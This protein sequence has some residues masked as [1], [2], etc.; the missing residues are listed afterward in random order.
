MYQLSA[1][2]RK[3][4]AIPHTSTTENLPVTLIEKRIGYSVV[5]KDPKIWMKLMRQLHEMYWDWINPRGIKFSYSKFGKLCSML[6]KRIHQIGIYVDYKT[7]YKKYKNFESKIPRSHAIIRNSYDLD[8]I[9]LVKHHGDDL[10]S[11]PG[12]KL[13]DGEGYGNALLRELYEEVNF[14]PNN[15]TLFVGNPKIIGSNACYEIWTLPR[16]KVR[17]NSPFEIDEVKWFSLK[18]MP[19]NT[20]LL[21]RYLNN[22]CIPWQYDR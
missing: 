18:K 9:L 10:W 19:S 17:T 20:R 16:S 5:V 4:C 7:V 1:I 15:N 6:W 12:G 11:L 13:E 14:T 2:R 3:I 8:K 21:R 22:Y